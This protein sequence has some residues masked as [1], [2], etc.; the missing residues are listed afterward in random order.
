MCPKM[1]FLVLLAIIIGGTIAGLIVLK[2]AAA[3]VQSSA[4]SNPFVKFISQ[5]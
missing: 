1:F 2:V 4:A 5:L 3:Q